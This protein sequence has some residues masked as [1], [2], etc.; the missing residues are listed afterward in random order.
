MFI[1]SLVISCTFTN[2]SFLLNTLSSDTVLTVADKN[3][4]VDAT[5]L[6]VRRSSPD[7]NFHN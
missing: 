2:G 4:H 7:S 5:S 6:S 1:V 3:D